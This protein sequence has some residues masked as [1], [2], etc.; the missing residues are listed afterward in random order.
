MT[1][2][3]FQGNPL[4]GATSA[5]AE[6]YSRTL[7]KLAAFRLDPLADADALIAANPDFLMAHVLRG[8]LFLVA[9]EPLAEPELRTSVDMARRLAAKGTEREQLHVV[10][11]E[12]WLQRDFLGASE[13][14]TQLT[15][16]FPRDL[17][18]LQ[19]GQQTDFFTGR[20]MELR[21]RIHRARWAWD[22][23]IPGAGF[24]D[25][26][27]AFGLEE[28]NQFHA[29]EAAGFRALE[30]CPGD[31]WAVHA[32]AHVAEMEGRS[33]DGVA[34]LTGRQADWSPD[35][36]LAYHNWWHLALFH[37]DRG[38]VDQ[39]NAIYDAQL[40]RA[41]G[42]PSMELVDATAMLWRL[43]LLGHDVE[44]RAKPLADAW[45]VALQA[46][47][48]G[49]FYAFNDVHAALAHVMSGRIGG[50]DAHLARLE[51]G[52][53]HPGS[54]A[55]ALADVGVPLVRAIY[56]FGAGDPGGAAD[57]LLACRAKAARLGGS[58]AQRDLLS[59][60]LLAAAEAAGQP[61]LVEALVAERRAAKPDSP[62]IGTILARLRA[63]EL[64]AQGCIA[65]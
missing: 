19:I 2:Q 41:P 9:A 4:T 20:T 53:R 36:I 13:A 48:A 62:F 45:D 18:G 22:R 3:D 17:L 43:H 14:Y 29:A 33:D 23:D 65:A 51:R 60:T 56:A 44:A 54:Y 34:F 21:D 30:A 37:M 40:C 25:G 15:A 57:L 63:D 12:R 42:A 39:V 55:H 31:A 16:R 47:T 61:T 28:N 10:A 58:N 24:I 26:M 52:A 5:C 27:L 35:N 1:A 46:E 64:E 38:E 32:V 6:T 8:A 7:L 49:A 11:L 50:A 59:W